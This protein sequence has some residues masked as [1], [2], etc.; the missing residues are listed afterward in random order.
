M[1]MVPDRINCAS[2]LGHEFKGWA[3]GEQAIHAAQPGG[4]TA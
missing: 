3:Y 2:A 4:C 1:Q